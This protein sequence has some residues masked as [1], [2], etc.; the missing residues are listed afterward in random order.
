[1]E[2]IER[3]GELYAYLMRGREHLQAL[4]WLDRVVQ[5]GRV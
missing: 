5:E 1:V 2:S 3:H 4:R